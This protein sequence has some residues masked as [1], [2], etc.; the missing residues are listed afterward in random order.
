[1]FCKKLFSDL[2]EHERPLTGAAVA[3]VSQDL[4]SY[5]AEFPLRAKSQQ[6]R[7]EVSLPPV[8]QVLCY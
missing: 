1:M 5:F 3:E 6:L 8:L 2:S 7:V 4:V